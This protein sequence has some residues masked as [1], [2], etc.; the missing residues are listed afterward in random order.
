MRRKLRFLCWGPCKISDQSNYMNDLSNVW[1]GLS[2]DR[3]YSC[4]LNPGN[5]QKSHVL[6][7]GV[8]LTLATWTATLV[9]IMPYCGNDPHHSAYGKTDSQ[10]SPHHASVVSDPHHST[11]GNM[12]SHTSH[13]HASVVS[14]LHHS[15]SG[16]MDSHASHHH[17]SVVSD[18]HHSTSGNTDSHTSHHHATVVSDPTTLPLATRTASLATIMPL[19]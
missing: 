14:D 6:L 18:P 17:A 8:N 10:T 1:E 9:T 7:F 19:W 12:D 15:T 11:S 5:L 2:S 3:N 16:N 13:H 4:T